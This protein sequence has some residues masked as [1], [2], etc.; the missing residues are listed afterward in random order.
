[1]GQS[2]GHPMAFNISTISDS[3]KDETKLDINALALCLTEIT[4]LPA[5]CIA[6][7]A[8][9]VASP[10]DLD[11]LELNGITTPVPVPPAQVSP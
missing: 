3:E 11:N 2:L 8:S 9:V 6:A 4:N 7:P 10:V 1:M 5:H